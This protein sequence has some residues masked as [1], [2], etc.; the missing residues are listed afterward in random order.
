[1]P[2]AV[3][4]DGESI[5]WRDQP[6]TELKPAEV[7][8]RPTLMGI[9]NTDLELIKGYRGFVG[10]LGH[11]FVGEVIEGD[12][13]WLGQRV[14][15]EINLVCGN[16][17]MCWRG[18]S[19]HCSN[20]TILG[21][22]GG[23][24]DGAFAES[25]RLD[26]QNLHRV[27][28]SVSD[29]QAVFAE[30]LAAAC[31]I[32]ILHHIEPSHRV[33]VIGLGKLGMLSAQVVAQTGAQVMGIIRRDKQRDLLGQ[34]GIATQRA[35]QAAPESFDYV[36]DCTGNASGFE[37]A[38]ALVRPRGTIVLKSTFNDLTPANLTD[39]VVREIRIEGSRCGP[40]DK[41]LGLL[42]AQEI[43]VISLID[44]KYPLDAVQAAMDRAAQRGTLKVLLHQ[45]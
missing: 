12:A 44:A 14:V 15:G 22:S 35:E 29:E 45:S 36:I 18:L 7:R 27:P 32:T 33:A 31:R 38:L 34:W 21:L 2:Y 16:C 41:A 13:A 9:C 25:F 39:V 28:D 23:E 8:I 1:M 20:R 26:S 6:T 37:S 40:F 5:A 4:W 10:R 11:E 3:V 42:A 19:T 17:D 24:Q 30:P 43:H